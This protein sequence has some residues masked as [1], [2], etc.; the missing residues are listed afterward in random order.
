MILARVVGHSVATVQH[1]VYPGKTV[2]LV[3]TVGPDGHTAD[4]EGFSAVDEVGA[5]IGDLVLCARE[6]NTARQLSGGPDDPFHSVVLAMVDELDGP[7]GVVPGP[8]PVRR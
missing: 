1:P 7:A 5:G 2:L 4:G 8:G 3:Q 6:G